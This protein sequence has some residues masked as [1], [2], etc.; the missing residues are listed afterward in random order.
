MRTLEIHDFN[1]ADPTK[2][3]EDL[4]ITDKEV[5]PIIAHC[6]GGT[7]RTGFFLAAYLMKLLSVYDPDTFKN[8]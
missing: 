6:T 5:K 7:G 8:L 2:F 3:I 1:A 4:G